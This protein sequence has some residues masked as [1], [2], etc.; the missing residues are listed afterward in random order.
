MIDRPTW[1]TLFASTRANDKVYLIKRPDYRCLHFFTGLATWQS[2]EKTDCWSEESFKKTLRQACG[3]SWLYM[4]HYFPYIWED[5]S[6]PT[7]WCPIAIV[8]HP[9]VIVLDAE[10]KEITCPLDMRLR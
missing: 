10:G 8:R 2:D 3:S 6:L 5:L 9:N 1:S 4:A 7:Y